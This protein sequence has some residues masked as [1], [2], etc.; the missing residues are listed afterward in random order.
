MARLRHSLL[1]ESPAVRHTLRALGT[2]TDMAVKLAPPDSRP[3]QPV[4]TI[5]TAPLCRLILDDPNGAAACRRFLARL[6]RQFECGMR[7]A[8]CGMKP[9]SRTLS[10]AKAGPARAI[11]NPHSAIRTEKCFAEL[12]EMAAAVNAHGRLA[13]T[14]VCGEFFSNKPA[15]RD[16]QRCLRRL[17]ALGIRLDPK[18]ARKAYFQTPIAPPA[19]VRAARQLLADL[20]EHLGE[21]TAHC[22]LER[23]NGDPPCVVCAQKLVAKNLAEI[24]STRGAAREA[25]VTEPYFCRMFKG[26]TGMTFSE[27]VARCHVDHARHL[28]R[29]PDLRVTEVA[30]AAGFQSIPHFNHTFKRYTGFSPNGYRASLAAKPG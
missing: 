10:E 21:M 5:G 30:Y 17:R 2:L 19:R 1:A 9:P 15:E 20:A 3:D 14:L 29:N 24:P 27:Y 11:R 12:T 22:L 18:R 8:E 23:E 26:A 7:N 13:A 6:Q 28:L 25:H 4:V 16:F